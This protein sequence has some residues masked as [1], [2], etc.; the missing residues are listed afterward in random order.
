[1]AVAATVL[2]DR[3]GRCSRRCATPTCPPVE[4]SSSDPIEQSFLARSAGDLLVAAQIEGMFA[5]TL[6]PEEIAQVAGLLDAI[7]GQGFLDAPLEGRTQIPLG[8][9]VADPAA[10]QGLTQLLLFYGAPDEAGGQPQLGGDRLP[11]AGLGR[12]HRCA[13][14]E[15]DR[16]GGVSGVAETLACDVVIVGRGAAAR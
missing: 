11:G 16:A 7:A 15:D 2:S 8:M 9:A 4:S 6:L 5:E 3:S 12:A 13:G 1:M 10:K 14:A